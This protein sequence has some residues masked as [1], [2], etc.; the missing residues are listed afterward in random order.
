MSCPVKIVLLFAVNCIVALWGLVDCNKTA[1]DAR[2][3]IFPHDQFPYLVHEEEAKQLTFGIQ[4]E[5]ED[6]V[7]LNVATTDQHI[8][9]VEN[10]TFQISKGST[11]VSVKVIGKFLG[12][13]LLKFSI[14]ENKTLSLEQDYDVATNDKSS[15]D[16]F[17]WYELPEKY[18]IAVGRDEGALSHSFT[19]L[20]IVLVVLANVAMGCKTELSVIKEVLKKPVAPLTGMFSQF[21]LMP[22]ISLAVVF[23]FNFDPVV[24]LGFFA[25]GCSPGGS[26]SNAYSYLLDGD[27]SLSVTMTFCSTI[28]ALGM[29][30]LWLFTV[31]QKVI[32]RTDVQIPYENILT[33]LA[34]LLIPVGIGMVIQ[35]KKPNWAKYIVKAIRPIMVIFFI[36]VFTLGVYANLYIFELMKNTPLIL[37]AGAIVPYVGFLFGGLVALLACQSWQRIRTI[38]IETGI[39]NTGIAI[40][41]LKVSLPQPDNDISIVAPIAAAIFTPIPM[42]IAITA[43]EIYKRCFKKKTE[44]YYLTDQGSSSKIVMNGIVDEYHSADEEESKSKENNNVR[45]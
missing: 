15:E 2:V 30:P 39:Q 10:R 25:M 11:N 9:D 31:G 8:A 38:A 43:Y 20:V 40:V 4:N 28:A 19:G 35:W 21:V 32:Y 42:L 26:A 27:V 45:A 7:H 16:Q 33:S 1:H 24:A 36:L 14:I 29:V 13:T 34:G 18:E 44:E 23:I 41:L 3:D 6:A 12:R 22:M 17:E 37:L 5:N